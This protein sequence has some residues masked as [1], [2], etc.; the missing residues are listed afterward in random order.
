MRNFLRILDHTVTPILS[1]KR[2]E[3]DR[4]IVY[5][6]KS[7]CIDAM[8]YF[9]FNFR[10]YFSHKKDALQ[11]IHAIKVG[12]SNNAGEILTCH[13]QYDY[14]QNCQT[15]QLQKFQEDKLKY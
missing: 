9:V 12:Q 6:S 11:I 2:I 4:D 15:S 14:Q 10:N 7:K 5:L 13:H 1:H 3:I 8:G